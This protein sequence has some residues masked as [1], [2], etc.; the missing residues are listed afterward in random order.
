MADTVQKTLTAKDAGIKVSNLVGDVV[1]PPAGVRGQP[2]SFTLTAAETG[3][4]ASTP[5]TFRID[6]EN[7]GSFDQTVVG[8]SGTVVSQ[9]SSRAGRYRGGETG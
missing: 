5:F 9:P 1:V 7:N 4:P 2:V 6:W 8:P 3:M